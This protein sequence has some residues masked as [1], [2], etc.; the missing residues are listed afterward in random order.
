[1]S[2]SIFSVNAQNKNIR[3]TDISLFAQKGDMAVGSNFIQGK[4]GNYSHYGMG[5]K[6]LYNVTDMFR[7]AAEYDFFPKYK[8]ISWWDFS[9]YGHHHLVT[10]SNRI[11]VYP[12]FRLGLAGAKVGNKDISFSENWL[13]FSLGGGIEFA[14]TSNLMFNIETR[15]ELFGDNSP[16]D[17]RSSLVGGYRTNL[18]SG[19]TY[20]F[21]VV[22][23]NVTLSKP[24]VDPSEKA[25]NDLPARK[26]DISIGGSIIYGIGDSYSYFG[27]GAKFLYNITAPIRLEGSF[28][29]FVPQ[30]VEEN[31]F[32]VSYDVKLNMWDVSV[33]GHYLFPVVNR[34][35]LYPSVGLGIVGYKM[36]AK[37]DAGIFGSK[38][39]SRSGSWFAYSLGGGID[40]SLSS[41]LLLN[42][43]LRYKRFVNDIIGAYRTN[44]AVGLTYKF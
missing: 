21:A 3:N 33:N 6:F 17:Y 43:E 18:A 41:N 31:V 36:E 42:G 16:S 29:Y 4:R 40:F 7:L 2:L 8:Y 23:N 34:I 37:A 11:A 38:S 25:K 27:I 9:I 13:A 12:L 28:T 44:F 15:Y 30:K 5:V 24:H 20:K 14:L 32:I 35:A 22:S 19:L 1:M 26:G 10:N 39:D